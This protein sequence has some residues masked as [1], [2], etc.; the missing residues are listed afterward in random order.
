MQNPSV[1]LS[2][3]SDAFDVAAIPKH[4]T[5]LDL[6]YI[7]RYYVQAWLRSLQAV[8]ISVY[9]FVDLEAILG[10]LGKAELSFSIYGPS[11]QVF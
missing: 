4:H 2:Y 5:S 8:I 6:R 7:V 1:L 10:A 11:L 9:G 3:W